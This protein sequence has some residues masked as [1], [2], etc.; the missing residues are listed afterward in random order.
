LI[1]GDLY[2]DFGIARVEVIEF[3]QKKLYQLQECT[4]KQPILL[5]GNHDMNADRTSTV[6]V[7]HNRLAMVVPTSGAPLPEAP[8]GVW[9]IN[10][11][12][13]NQDFVEAVLK[14]YAEGYRYFICHAE[15]AGSRMDNGFYSPNGIDLSLLP[16]DVRFLSGHIHTKQTIKNVFYPGTARQHNFS[17]LGKQKG[18]HIWDTDVRD[19]NGE[20]TGFEFIPTPATVSEPFSLLPLDK[21]SDLS[22]VPNS[23]RIYVELRGSRDFIHDA[24]KK[25]PGAVK[26]RESY[27]DE[28]VVRD[29]SEAEGVDVA[30]EKFLVKYMGDNQ[31]SADKAEMIR[32]RITQLLPKRIGE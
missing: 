26:V 7:A 13:E 32:K 10:F 16:P 4:G 24:R 30:F 5:A 27:D 12:Q 6:L 2:H 18:F 29:I 19:V 14:A 21:N 1:L 28:V 15:F 8:H 22:S 3:W 17:D 20:A 11:K 23:D 31:I 9:C 25:L